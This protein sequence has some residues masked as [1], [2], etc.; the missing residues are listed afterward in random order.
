MQWGL[1]AP[2]CE[3]GSGA[4][5]GAA[6]SS[7]CSYECQ[8]PLAPHHPPSHRLGGSLR[9]ARMPF[10]VCAAPPAVPK[11]VHPGRCVF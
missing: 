1:A 11:G 3:R 8:T 6:R 9:E 2:R 5:G 10:Q 4:I 7:A